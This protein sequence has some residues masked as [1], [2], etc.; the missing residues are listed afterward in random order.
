MARNSPLAEIEGMLF[1][2]SS[3]VEAETSRTWD[4]TDI[5]S[6]GQVRV[7]PGS[8]LGSCLVADTFT[9][10]VKNRRRGD[11]SYCQIVTIVRMVVIVLR[12]VTADS[13]E[14]TN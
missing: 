1:Y 2:A 11:V 8:G 12:R 6:K 4:G 13:I 3:S 7:P 10:W 5:P 9:V 14:I